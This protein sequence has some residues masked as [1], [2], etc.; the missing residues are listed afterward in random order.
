MVRPYE[1]LDLIGHDHLTVNDSAA[2]EPITNLFG[3][4]EVLQID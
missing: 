3:P 2:R 1:S 4:T